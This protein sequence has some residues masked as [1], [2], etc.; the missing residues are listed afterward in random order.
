MIFTTVEYWICCLYGKARGLSMYGTT[1]MAMD[2]PLPLKGALWNYWY[3]E[4]KIRSV[5]GS[6]GGGKY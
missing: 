5:Y 4:C 6:S 3:I 2:Y 1:N